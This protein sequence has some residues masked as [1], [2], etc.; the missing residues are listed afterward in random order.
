LPPLR[1]RGNDIILLSKFFIEDY[2]K[3]N[4]LPKVNLSN[5]ASQKLLGYS[6]PGN[7][8]EL[9]AIIE[10]ACVMASDETIVSDDLTF[11]SI[12][13]EGAFILEEVSLREYTRRIIRHFLNKYDDDVLLVADKLDIGKSTIYNMLKSGDL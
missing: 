9:K 2:C 11:N 12:K 4:R 1:E 13:P 7:I 5:E 8:R 3:R 10:L 6:F